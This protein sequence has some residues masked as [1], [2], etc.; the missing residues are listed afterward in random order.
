VHQGSN[1]HKG[2]AEALTS[3]IGWPL[4]LVLMPG[5]NPSACRRKIADD[6]QAPAACGRSL[7]SCNRP[8][9]SA[10][11]RTAAW[12]DQERSQ[13]GFGV[14]CPRL[15]QVVVAAPQDQGP[16]ARSTRKRR[17]TRT[18]REQNLHR[19]DHTIWVTSRPVRGP[20][21]NS[22]RASGRVSAASVLQHSVRS[23]TATASRTK[24]CA[25]NHL[26]VPLPTAARFGSEPETKLLVRSTST[27]VTSWPTT[28]RRNCL[29]IP[30]GGQGAPGICD[31]A[32][33]SRVVNDFIDMLRRIIASM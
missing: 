8:G 3:A 27:A 29:Q 16:R 5:L 32:A 12:Q 2:H 7:P 26:H 15:W 31:C 19:R 14:I 1:R 17:I 11:H 20:P 6:E 23:S 9:P 10:H 21:R 24:L 18:I 33:W 28:T 13:L 30:V 4:N 22:C 25:S